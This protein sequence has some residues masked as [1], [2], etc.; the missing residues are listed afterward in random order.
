[1][2]DVNCLEFLPY[3]FLLASVGKTGYL[4]YQDTSTGQFLCES[5]TKFGDCQVMKQNPSNA[6]L[7]LGHTNGTVTMWTPNMPKPVVTMKTHRAPVLAIGM[8]I[9]GNMLVTSGVDGQVKIWDCRTYREL[10]SYF[11]VRPTT[12][13]DVSDQGLLALGYGP[14]VQVWKDAFRTKQSAPYMFQQLSGRTVKS[15]EFSPYEDV[16][17]VGHS[18]GFT[19][20]VIPGAGEAN[21]DSYEANPF[22]TNKQRREATVHSLLEKLQ[23]DMITL[24]RQMFGMMSKSSKVVFEG[25]RKDMRLQREQAKKDEAMAVNKKRGKSK[26]S[27]KVNRKN[28]NIIDAARQER[29]DNA[30]KTQQQIVARKK[31]DERIAEGKPTSALERF[32]R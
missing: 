5:R 2:F 1:M 21:F 32:G 16:L 24:E 9:G 30:T 29:I 31:E 3:H 8:D 11:T 23:P 28:S 17:G 15:V 19:S 7:C 20:L 4:K 6:V 12:T 25:E 18:G 10:H 13:I 22:Q 27:K 14:H 26:S